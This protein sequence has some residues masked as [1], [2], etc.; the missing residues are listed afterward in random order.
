[1]MPN[2]CG[3]FTAVSA[4]GAET[5]INRMESGDFLPDSKNERVEDNCLKH[6]P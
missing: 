3:L 6:F 4:D 2:R 5:G 1:M